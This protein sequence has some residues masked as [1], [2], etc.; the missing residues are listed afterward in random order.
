MP[1][2]MQTAL[3]KFVATGVIAAIA[4]V[5][6]QVWLDVHH[7]RADR[8]QWL[9]E[10]C[11]AAFRAGELD[12]AAGFAREAFL[13]EPKFTTPNVWLLRIHR[14]AG[15][16]P[17]AAIAAGRLEGPPVSAPV[18]RD[19]SWA[20]LHVGMPERAL[21]CA[22]RA[23]AIDRSAASSHMVGK[24]RQALAARSKRRA[25]KRR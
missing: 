19:R 7:A 10:Q 22:E 1:S 14:Q 9:V 15:S 8:A 6:P 25:L 4:G 11:E 3:N 21:T 5:L 17:G 24:A 16:A 2:M 13:L 23:Y 12:R 20:Y 18:E